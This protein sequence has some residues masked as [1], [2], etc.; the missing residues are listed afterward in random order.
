MPTNDNERVHVVF[1]LYDPSGTYSQHAGVVITS[2]FEHTNSPVTVHIIHDDT[3]NDDNRRK[4]IKTAENFSQQVNLIN[5]T[6]HGKL[7]DSM[8]AH[9]S[10][11][12][13]NKFTGAIFRLL[14]PDV[15]PTDIDKIIYLDCDLL[16]NLDIRELWDVDLGN[17][18]LAGR[19]DNGIGHYSTYAFRLK[20][21][22]CDV[23]TYVNA[24]VM[25]MDLRK[26]R[27]L[28][29]L[30]MMC[31][32]WFD[33]Y[34][35]I[36]PGWDQDVL[37]S[38]FVGKI[39]FLDAK[40]NVMNTPGVVSNCIIHMISSKPWKDL[41]GYDYERLYWKILLRTEWGKALTREELIDKFCDMAQSSKL[42]HVHK[43]QC[44]KRLLADFVAKIVKVFRVTKRLILEMFVRLKYKLLKKSPPHVD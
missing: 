12:L 18:I 6:E 29:S 3:L 25:V 5:I 20:F 16:V 37:N 13:L 35:Q 2:L 24:G 9:S 42:I 11:K 10:A 14:I 27:A 32:E 39:K 7:F 36:S 4:F 30:C 44:R 34:V 31:L 26:L 38:L 8:K 17:N 41:I 1:C 43:G 19:F 21:F 23:K 40:F 22:G 33:R 28:G 15:V